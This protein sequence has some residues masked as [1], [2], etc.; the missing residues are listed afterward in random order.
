M[1]S[2]E[3][4]KIFKNTFFYRTSPCDCSWSLFG[5]LFIC[6]DVSSFCLRYFS[7]LCVIIPCL[8]VAFNWGLLKDCDIIS[9]KIFRPY[10]LGWTKVA[11][12]LNGFEA[13]SY[14]LKLHQKLPF[15]RYILFFGTL[16]FSSAHVKSLM[17]FTYALL[18]AYYAWFWNANKFCL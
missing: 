9:W 1:F 10:P 11:F 6:F 14:S 8:I 17:V 2:C 12:H 15:R 4:C 7:E 13:H 5:L 16:L 3:F 18:H